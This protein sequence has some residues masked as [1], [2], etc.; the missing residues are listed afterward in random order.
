MT[1]QTNVLGEFTLE[2]MSTRLDKMTA[3]TYLRHRYASSEG[4][5]GCRKTD[6]KGETKWPAMGKLLMKT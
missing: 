3:N 1:S 4:K 2:G 6:T 5:K